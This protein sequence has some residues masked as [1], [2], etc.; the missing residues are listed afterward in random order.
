M[1]TRVLSALLDLPQPT[2]L[3]QDEAIV[4]VDKPAGMPCQSPDATQPEDLPSLLRRRLA[5]ER[6]LPPAELYL[7]THQ[8][9][10]QDT[11]GV[12]VYSAAK[13]ANASLAE[14]FAART[15]EKV[16]LAA[17]SGKPPAPGT[18]LSDHIAPGEGG[19]MRVV[20]A[21][22]RGA[23]QARTRVLAVRSEG[24]R[25][26][27]TLQI[28]TGR[29]HQIRVQLAAAGCPVAGDPWYGG[30]A[31]LR[32]LLHA[33]RL[34]LAHP[35]RGERVTFESPLPPE[36][37]CFMRGVGDP[38][39]DPRL[40]QRALIL[41]AHKRVGLL[42]S[43]EAGE[44]DTFRWLHGAADGIPD[45][46]IDVYD[47]QLVVRVDGDDRQQHERQLAA[48]LEPFGF[49]GAQLKRHPRQANVLVDPNDDAVAPRAPLFGEQA[50]ET[51]IVK[52][53]GL[54]FEV[55]LAE[56][57]R[58]GLF[59]DQRDNRARL[60]E[61]AKGK[62]VLNLFGYT[63]SFSVAA[64]LGGAASALTVD[65]SRA[66]LEWA[67]RNVERIG[68]SERHRSLAE[69]VFV[70]LR[71][72]AAKGQRF[73][74][75]VLDP[76]SYSTTKRGRFRAAK[77]YASLCEAALSVLEE[78][79]VLLAC[80]NHQGMSR[81]QLRRDVQRGAQAAGRKIISLQD[82]PA[83]RDFPAPHGEEPAMKS[84]IARLSGSPR[85]HSPSASMN[86]RMGRR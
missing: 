75:I 59:L 58:S 12:L 72:L 82:Q 67:A 73:D 80:L 71:G 47:Q 46:Y 3:Y 56:G 18:L 8:R 66:A 9:L 33:S 11:S 48:A 79:G 22:A 29:T 28:E 68:C 26:L 55:H 37:E 2:V 41:A 13:A 53:H 20:P 65:V 62:R 25:S 21:S 76:P 81:A 60:R 42:P 19:L 16:Y 7:G 63:G 23:K 74:R 52:E 61:L 78:E 30:A 35:T 32:M 85:M 10:D 45:V 27:L 15:V 40:L 17:V 39:A 31:A 14:Q 69:D 44:T 86:T 49:A 64:L 1:R 84:V 57:L 83:Q 4:V 38:F 43:V 50:S 51:A 24:P 70:A 54:P 36:F 34:S 5:R 6:G 77:D